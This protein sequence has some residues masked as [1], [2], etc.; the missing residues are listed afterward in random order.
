M[1]QYSWR[2]CNT[3]TISISNAHTD[4]NIKLCMYFYS[5]SGAE[6][7]GGGVVVVGLVGLMSIDHPLY[8]F[9]MLTETAKIVAKDRILDVICAYA[10]RMAIL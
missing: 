3:T 7:G 8:G 6:L 1:D 5:S 4:P 9:K 10:V 2:H